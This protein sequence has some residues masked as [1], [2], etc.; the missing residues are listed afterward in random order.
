VHQRWCYPQQHCCFGPTHSTHTHARARRSTTHHLQAQQLRAKV[1]TQ[2]AYDLSGYRQLLDDL[3]GVPPSE[4]VRAAYEELVAAFPTAVSLVC[5]CV[6]AC[7]RACMHA[8]V[9]ACVRACVLW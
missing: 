7:V 4:E 6:C 9:R 2:D 3:R 8:C 5:A 1:V